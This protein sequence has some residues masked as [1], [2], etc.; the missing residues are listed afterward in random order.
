MRDMCISDLTSSDSLSQI[1]VCL[2]VKYGS[3]VMKGA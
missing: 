3:N 2:P 1:W